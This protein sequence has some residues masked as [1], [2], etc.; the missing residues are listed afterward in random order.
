MTRTTYVV[1]LLLITGM[2]AARFAHTDILWVEEAYASAAAAQVL[3]GKLLY[4]D[5]W[6]D[7]P[8]LYALV[9]LLWGAQPGIG[10][11][12]AGALF[13]LLCC[14]LAYRLARTTWSE[15]EGLFAAFLLAFFLTFGI[16]SAVLALAPDLLMMAPHLLAIHLA[17]TGR[18]FW[19]GFAAGI[20]MLF[21]TKAV[22]VLA[23]GALFGLRS[24]PALLGGFLLPNAAL[25]AILA[26]NGALGEYYRQVWRWGFLYSGDT[27]LANPLPSGILKTLN[28]AGFHAAA[29]LASLYY[30]WRE[31]DSGKKRVIGWAALSLISVAAGWR[32]FPRYYFQFLPP[33]AIAAS[34]GLVLMPKAWRM[35]VL[36]LLLVPLIRF[37]P[38]YAELV[39]DLI[40]D[41]PHIWS[42]LAMNQDSR[43][44]GALVREMASPG[45]TL[46][47][48]GY[49][50]DI[51][52]YSG[53]PAGT[54]FL[55][56]QPLTGVL[57]DRHLVDSRSTAPELARENR[58]KLVR[59]RP[60][61]IVDGLGPYNPRLAIHQYGDLS[62]WLSGYRLA[63][64]TPGARI[65]RLHYSDATS[66]ASRRKTYF[67]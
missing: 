15:R 27:F 56:S 1:V 45:D 52:V 62:E 12:L 4:R 8:P 57:A 44:A 7:K 24:L 13:V 54:R 20:A 10:L 58:R 60:A 63:A 47:V 25:L 32:F 30:F 61:F 9:Y 50:P 49:R 6:F 29:V 35:L 64:E 39:A 26:A 65:Y 23:A 34:R 53:L 16:P 40:R 3:D 41:Q 22:F 2:A 11:R 48:W 36:C 37:G 14:L 67:K 42:D 66:G 19:S 46:L 55:D 17:W 31:H 51:F 21:N 38:S 33:V 43:K 28:W 5:I 59:T 18:P